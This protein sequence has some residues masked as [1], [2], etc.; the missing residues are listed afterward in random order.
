MSE[1]DEKTIAILLVGGLALIVVPAMLGNLGTKLTA[2]GLEHHI[3]VPAQEALF[4]LPGLDAG[5]DA[6][7]VTILMLALVATA[8]LTTMRRRSKE[9]TS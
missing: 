5:L 4:T 6:R 2:W 8:A 7:R 9:E 3:L 1:E